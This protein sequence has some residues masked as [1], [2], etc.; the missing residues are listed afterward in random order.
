MVDVWR[1][2]RIVILVMVLDII[3]VLV[4]ML[5]VIWI[6][7]NVKFVIQDVSY[8]MELDLPIVKNVNLDTF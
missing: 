3:H 5:I 1:V 7:E 6:M 4:V 8:V 2:I